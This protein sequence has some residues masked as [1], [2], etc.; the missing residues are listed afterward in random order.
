MTEPAADTNGE[1]VVTD[2]RKEY[3]TPAGPLVVLD[4]VS[5]RAMPGESLAIVGPSGSGKST[6]LNILGALDRPTAG[7]VMLDG[8]TLFALDDAGLAR[9]RRDRIGFV[10]QDHHLL[11]QCTAAENV[12]VPKLAGG[13]ASAADVQRAADL[14][15]QV[16]LA[17]R[18]THFPHELSGGERQ[19]VA[20]ARALMNRP[21]LLL[22]DEP[23]GNLDAKA[24][25]GV[26]EVLLSLARSAEVILVVVT[27]SAALAQRLQRR[28]KMQEG[29]LVDG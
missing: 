23:T 7:T 11:P 13:R 1:L 5:L 3:P 10:F 9:F 12:L 26:T 18:R 25:E 20:I 4:G 27:H 19:R 8:I 22:C 24:A 15:N 29:V 2:L 21:P 6:L 16:G 17:E 14:L 28:L